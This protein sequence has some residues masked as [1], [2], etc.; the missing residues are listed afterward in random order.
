MSSTL[1]NALLCADEYEQDAY[2]QTFN[3]YNAR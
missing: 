2:N 3:S 1:I